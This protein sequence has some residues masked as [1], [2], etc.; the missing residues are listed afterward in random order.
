MKLPFIPLFAFI[1]LFFLINPAAAAFNPNLILSDADIFD[2]SGMTKERLISFLRSKGTLA[3]QRVPDTDGVEKSVPDILWRVSQSYKINPKYLVALLQKEQSLVEDPSPTAKQFDWATGYGVCDACA[4][5][6]P[7]LAE[8][9]GFASQVEW[10]AKQH[11][12]KY[13]I[14]LLTD[15]LTIGGFGVGVPREI[16]GV[17]VTPANR[18]T[19]MLYSYTPHIHGN[20]VLWNIWN[21]WFRV[22]YPDG[23]LVRNA[24]SGDAFLIRYGE[25]RPFASE[26]V[27]VSLTDPERAIP[28]SPS[29]L[30]AYPTG[31]E[32][33]FPRWA[34]LREPDGT[35]YLY[36]GEEKRHIADMETFRKFGF[37]TDEIIPVGSD[38][39][40]DIP[41]GT[42]ITR[43]TAF[44]QG[45]LMRLAG[46][47]NIYYVE[48]G[49]RHPIADPIY[50]KLYFRGRQIRETTAD[51]IGQYTLGR[52]YEL[53]AGELVRSSDAPAVYVVENDILRPIPSAEVFESVGWDW[54]RVVFLPDS[55]ITLYEIGPLLDPDAIQDFGQTAIL[56][57]QPL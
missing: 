42:E 3:D 13:L 11:R 10:A 23:T 15:G 16:D 30:D 46:T 37:N 47:D 52:P 6:D 25:K 1:L 53:H 2:A 32:I 36:T 28:V 18:A 19:A 40:T 33:K 41:F 7:D 9:K 38:D 24:E 14:Q 12:E 34:L 50:L 44:P 55:L 21:R 20:T 45:V 49:V 5:D 22:T 56:A 35:I 57:S 51:E 43:D 17:V 8:L 27:L 29:D 39:I 48:D 4:K 54:K 26:S 31:P